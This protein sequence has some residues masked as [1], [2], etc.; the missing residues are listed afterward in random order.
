MTSNNLQSSGDEQ[1]MQL[2]K[3]GNRVAFDVLFERHWKTLYRF[4]YSLFNEVELVEDCLQEIF[5]S[6]WERKDDLDV[7]NVKSYLFQA[8]RYKV[9][10]QIRQIKHTESMTEVIDQVKYSREYTSDQIDYDEMVSR[11]LQITE[12][13]PKRCAQIFRM[14]RFEHLTNR[15]ISEQLNI[16]IRTVENQITTALHHIKKELREDSSAMLFF[17]FIL[18]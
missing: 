6:I 17:L 10:S 14:S 9:A 15:E 7:H 8:V 13:L 4:A 18:I 1:L 11:I 16:S 2:I 5:V 3:L 12:K